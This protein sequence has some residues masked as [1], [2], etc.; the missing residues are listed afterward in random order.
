MQNM[1]IKLT[2]RDRSGVMGATMASQTKTHPAGARLAAISSHLL[3]THRRTS[4]T[5]PTSSQHSAPRPSSIETPQKTKQA[6]TTTSQWADP[7]IYRYWVPVQ[8]RWSVRHLILSLLSTLI[9]LSS[10]FLLPSNPASRTSRIMTFT[11]T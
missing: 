5:S 6:P 7:H 9:D 8:T 1:L 11:D 4:S 10:R 3:L 2:A